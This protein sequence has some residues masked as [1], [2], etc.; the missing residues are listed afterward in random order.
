M[1]HYLPIAILLSFLSSPVLALD[2]KVSVVDPQQTPLANIVV[3]FEA[4][5]QATLEKIAADQAAYITRATKLSKT[6]II[7]QR[8]KSFTPY[9]SVVQKGDPVQFSNQDDITHHIYSPVGGNKFSFKIR[10]GQQQVNQSFTQAGEVPMGCNIHDWMSGYLLILDTPYFGKTNDQGQTDITLKY[11][12][13]YKVTLW[14]PQMNE[15][16][17]RLSQV[18]EVHADTKLAMS[19]QQAMSEVPEQKNDDDFD[20]LSDY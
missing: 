4:L 17:N 3:Y 5:E 16:N 9:I 2:V 13:Q 19:L 15:P 11:Q 10:A 20:F 7:G 8:D 12:G 14:H 18:I 6:T 1:K